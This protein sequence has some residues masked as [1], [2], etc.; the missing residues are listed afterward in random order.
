MACRRRLINTDKIPSRGYT[1]SE[2]NPQQKYCPGYDE[3]LVCGALGSVKYFFN[4]ITLRF[5]GP[6]G[7]LRGGGRRI[8]WLHLCRGVRLPPTKCP[9]CDS[10]QSAKAPVMQELWGIRSSQEFVSWAN[11]YQL[12]RRWPSAFVVLRVKLLPSK[13][14]LYAGAMRNSEFPSL[15]GPLWLRVVTPDRTL[16]MGQI[17]LNYVL[18]TNWIFWNR[19][20]LIFNCG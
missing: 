14:I 3:A 17:A 5:S 11:K 7:C 4:G 15:L 9:G 8:Y 18:I 13:S 20:V 2:G 6:V 19:A 16:S 12:Q 1:V 10:K